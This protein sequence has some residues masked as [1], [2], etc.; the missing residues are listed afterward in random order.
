[1]KAPIGLLG[2]A[3]D[4]NQ[5]RFGVQASIDFEKNAVG[6]KAAGDAAAAGVKHGVVSIGV[7]GWVTAAPNNP[8]LSVHS[9][10]SQLIDGASQSR[11]M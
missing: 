8:H 7:C 4:A 6:E 9:I 10:F 11:G 5:N 2:A 3:V 1:M